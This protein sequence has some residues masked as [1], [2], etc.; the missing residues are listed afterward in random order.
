MGESGEEEAG[1]RIIRAVTDTELDFAL[2]WLVVDME[3]TRRGI[4]E[5]P[6][7]GDGGD[8]I[9][10]TDLLAIADEGGKPDC[11][12]DARLRNFSNGEDEGVA[13]TCGR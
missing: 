9:C 6:F 7:S 13:D 8:D 3:S 5:V 4:P 11:E 2:T 1:S 10:G 12:A